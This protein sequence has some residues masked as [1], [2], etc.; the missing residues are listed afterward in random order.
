ML[1]P[2]IVWYRAGQ[3]RPGP[4]G[5]TL[6]GNG[7]GT[8]EKTAPPGAAIS[9][10]PPPLNG[11]I[12]PLENADTARLESSEATAM[13]DGQLAGRPTGRGGFSRA[14]VNGSR[15]SFPAAAMISVPGFEFSARWATFS[16]KG[17][18]DSP[19]WT[20]EPSDMEMMR[21]LFAIAQL[22]PARMPLSAPDPW[23]LNTLPTK[24]VPP[25]AQPY[26]RTPPAGC[27]G[28]SAVP[29]QCVPCPL[30]SATA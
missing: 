20:R 29:M 16:Y 9:M 23:L 21:Q 8:E 26:R 18:K 10:P 6:A 12:V 2:E 4:V 5:C 11:L 27:W 13:I 14:P 7:V 24:I 15:L 22:M 25:K 28:P 1:V 3:G 19:G 30:K 17:E